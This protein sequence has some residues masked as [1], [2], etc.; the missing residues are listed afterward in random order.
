MRQ[1]GQKGSKGS[2]DQAF[3][4]GS[5]PGSER[6]QRQDYAEHTGFGFPPQSSVV[7]SKIFCAKSGQ[8]RE[9]PTLVIRL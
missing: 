1:K 4:N 6:L 9:V 7:G 8:A 3:G 5:E 2:K